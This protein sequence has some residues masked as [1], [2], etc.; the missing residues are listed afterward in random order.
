[1]VSQ[2][3]DCRWSLFLFVCLFSGLVTVAL[4][5]SVLVLL[6]YLSTR[7]PRGFP[8][9][10]KWLPVLGSL[11]EVSKLRK[12]T[13]YFSESCN[14]LSA[15]YGSIIGLKIGFDKIVILNDFESMKAM[16]TNEDC[17][18]RPVGPVYESRT[19]GKRRG[20]IVVDG[21]LWTQQRRFIL[22]QLRDFGFGRT[23][24]ALQIEFE[25]AQL[26]KYYEGLIR[27]NAS[28][29][30]DRFNNNVDGKLAQ[31][32]AKCNGKIYCLAEGDLKKEDK[33]E[34]TEEEVPMKKSITAEDFYMKIDD[35]AEI[36]EAAKVPGIIV[37][38]EDFFGV[39]VLNTLWTMMAGKRYNFNDEELIY[40]QRIFTRLLR[41]VDMFGCLFGHFPFLRYIAPE[42]SG[43]RK[44][45][46]IHAQVWK[47]LRNELDNHKKTFKPEAPRDLMD[48]YLNVLESGNPDYDHTFTESQLL[49]ICVD[50][51]IAGSETTSKALSFGFLYLVLNP[52]VQKKAQHEL[53]L[54]VGRERLPSL[55]DRAKLPYM[56]A[57]VWESIRMFM[58]R[59]MNVPHRA[60]K[61]TTIMG[62]KIPKDTML[63]VNFNQI[64]MGD[65]WGD[66]EAFRPERF[67]DESGKLFLP[68]KFL[69]F[70]FGKHR[71]IGE[72][73]AKSNVFVITA[74]LLQSF[75]FAPVPGEDPPRN[76][77]VD[78]VTASPKPFRVLMTKRT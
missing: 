57:V 25:A 71:C 35:D 32:K 31:K 18:G 34:K 75:T 30:Y 68:E 11:L 7:K 20:L 33:E 39:P 47:F 22:R 29:F 72:V 12:E 28:E 50:L 59:T 13:G 26:V 70:S 53:D 40:L 58:G 37:E 73:L 23:D 44:F 8:P 2:F 3:H 17:D 45:V 36:R 54:V 10:P 61:D 41:D 78:G 42:M 49:A 16:I 4:L 60:T 66:P 52:K 76:E 74:A 63:V 55:N 65:F 5:C 24:M 56:N 6:Y 19:F 43:Y 67:I 48:V 21:H 69:P 77:Y 51:F 62:Y 27:D 38:M 14:I 1:M 9:G 64:L 46:E 15:K